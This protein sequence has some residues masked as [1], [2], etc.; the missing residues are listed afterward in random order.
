M[1]GAALQLTPGP[2]SYSLPDA[3]RKEP[4]PES[5]QFFGVL[6]HAVPHRARR[7]TAS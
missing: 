1:T 3:F 7:L 2:G 6:L 4:V 5:M